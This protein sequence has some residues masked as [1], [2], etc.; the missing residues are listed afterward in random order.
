MAGSLE[1]GQIVWAEIADANGILKSRPAVIITPD[2]QI[3]P[4]GTF[5]SWR[6]QASWLI[7][8]LPIMSC[9]LGT[10]KAIRARG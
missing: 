3:T 8:C 4:A 9:C 6:S 2:D 1:C 5:Q 10:V 7:R